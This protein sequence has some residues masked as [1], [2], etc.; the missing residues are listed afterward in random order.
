[1]A[2]DNALTHGGAVT[3]LGSPIDLGEVD[4]DTYI[5]A[6]SSDHIVPWENAYRS[7]QL[8]GGDARFVLSTS[9]HIQAL[10]NP[11]APEGQESRSSYRVADEHPP[12][13]EEW[14]SR[15]PKHQGSWWPDYVDWIAARSGE[16]TAAPKRLGD[17]KHRATAKAPGNY[18]HAA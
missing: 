17:A 9:G 16:L 15:A 13:A 2:L 5:V 1:M 14:L 11:P 8:L 7:T 18:V 3:A 10:I 4:V 12:S 6:G